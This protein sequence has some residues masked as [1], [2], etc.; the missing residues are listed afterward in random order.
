[1]FFEPIQSSSSP[2]VDFAWLPADLVLTQRAAAVL[3]AYLSGNDLG[4]YHLFHCAQNE[5]WDVEYYLAPLGENGAAWEATP[6]FITGGDTLANVTVEKEAFAR[7]WQCGILRMANHEVVIGR[8]HWID[9]EGDLRILTLCAAHSPAHFFRLRKELL[10]H[11]RSATTAQWQI[12]RGNAHRDGPRTPRVAGGSELLISDLL[13]HGLDAD[14]LRFFTDG[15]AE[16]Y[17]AMQ[18]PYRR[19]VLLHGPPGNGKTSLIRQIGAQLPAVPAMI[20]RPAAHFGSD[21]LEEVIRRWTLQAPA[22]LVIEDLNWL[23]EQV[24]V[25]T[26][27]NLLDGI[28]SAVNGGLL[29]IA[30]TNYPQQLDP[31]IN[32]RPGRFDVVIEVCAPDRAM[33]R[34]FLRRQLPETALATLEKVAALTEDL[35]FA[36]LQ[37]IL[38]LS[39]LN[40]IH[41]GRTTRS[42]ADVLSAATAVR[43]SYDNAI[44]GFPQK[45]ELPFGL[46]HL[47][48]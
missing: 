36:H 2:V 28:D 30:T 7:L 6:P 38:R 45:P 3:R 40:A 23:L 32:N 19:G 27:L 10:A 13:R 18:V 26:F 35:S 44:R 43:E 48:K 12:V 31:A 25:S 37:E 9:G 39:G 15:V 8:W 22:M 29:L 34:A 11:R 33:R 14:I 17:R 4:H 20:L 41:A 46:L 5:M 21:D 42:D 24:N 1:M 47:R 16:L